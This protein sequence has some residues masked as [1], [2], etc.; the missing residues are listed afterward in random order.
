MNNETNYSGGLRDHAIYFCNIINFIKKEM[1]PKYD[2]TSDE[3][4]ELIKLINDL[5]ENKQV[6]YKYFVNNIEKR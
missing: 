1:I 5:E 2:I 3:Y 4:L 6:Y